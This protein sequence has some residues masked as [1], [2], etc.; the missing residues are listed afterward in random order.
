[1]NQVARRPMD[2]EPAASAPASRH[3]GNVVWPFVQAGSVQGI[4]SEI[5]RGICE[6]RRRRANAF[7]AK[8][9]GDPTWD[10]LL[11]LYAARLEA[12][13]LSITRL[14]KLCG[15]PATTVL[16]RLGVLEEEGLVTRTGDPFDVRR[17]YVALSFAG[18]EAMER[19]FAASGL[20][21][22]FL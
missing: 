6:L 10:I 16:R 20:G 3:E 17:I 9:F 15:L 18:S 21:A 2:F 11:Q 1:V 14:T 4:T 7:P 19:C 12:Q 22:A 13:R 8:L 5:V